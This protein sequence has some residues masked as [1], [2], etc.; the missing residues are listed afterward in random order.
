M[1]TALDHDLITIILL[2]FILLFC[3]WFGWMI[4]RQWKKNVFFSLQ[5]RGRAGEVTSIS[6]LKRHGY[7]IIDQQIKLE[8]HIFIDETISKFDLRPDFLVEK[9]GNRYIAEIKTGEVANPK[10]RNTRRQLHEYS[11]YGGYDVI[12]LVDPDT[13]SITRISFR[14]P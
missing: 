10:N 2:I 4:R 9:N 1:V 8:G 14:K 5:R 3:I 12:L 6:I 11:Y 7:K 13:M